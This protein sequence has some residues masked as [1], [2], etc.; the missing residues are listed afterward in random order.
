ME[1]I[2]HLALA[3]ASC[4]DVTSMVRSS[5]PLRRRTTSNSQYML[6][7]D[8]KHTWKK[9]YT[10]YYIAHPVI[11]KNSLMLIALI[12]PLPQTL[13]SILNFQNSS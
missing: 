13:D 2:D 3:V 6:F 1:G 12:E 8:A 4:M 7:I 5:L 11:T 10:S 9:V